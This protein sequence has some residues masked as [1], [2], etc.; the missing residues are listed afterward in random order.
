[1]VVN[2][3]MIKKSAADNRRKTVLFAFTRLTLVFQGRFFQFSME[4]KQTENLWGVTQIQT[5][6]IQ[7]CLSV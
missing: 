5:P 6:I 1:M 3:D 7:P 4:G 2:S